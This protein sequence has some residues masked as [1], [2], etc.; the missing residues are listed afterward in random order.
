MRQEWLDID[1]GFAHARAYE[2]VTQ[3]TMILY[4]NIITTATNTVEVHINSILAVI[5]LTKLQNL[6]NRP[7]KYTCMRLSMVATSLRLT[8]LHLLSTYVISIKQQYFVKQEK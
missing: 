6:I 2:L 4:L 1:I 3:H 7:V 5:Y 8:T